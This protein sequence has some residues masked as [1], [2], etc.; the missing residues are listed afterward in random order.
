[1]LEVW[2]GRLV[3]RGESRWR[4]RWKWKGRWTGKWSRDD[5]VY[6]YGGE[7]GRGSIER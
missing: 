4:W 5:S 3:E 7:G 6:E 2:K 1:M